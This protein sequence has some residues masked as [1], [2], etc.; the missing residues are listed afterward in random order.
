M[1]AGWPAQWPLDG[2]VG[3]LR[4]PLGPGLALGSWLKWSPYSSLEETSQRGLGEGQHW[5]FCHWPSLRA[6][7]C[8]CVAGPGGWGGVR[9]NEG[10]RAVEMSPQT[11]F[12]PS[13]TI[14][15]EGVP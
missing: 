7:V 11:A 2:L 14:P 10:I 6:V 1:P 8:V 9:D 12:A 5:P 15:A 4:S 3:A 13:A